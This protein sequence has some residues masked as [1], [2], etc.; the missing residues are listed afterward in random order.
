MKNKKRARKIIL[1][2]LIG[3]I[4]IMLIGYLGIAFIIRVT[5]EGSTINGIDC[6]NK[7]VDEVKESIIEKINEYTLKIEE[8]GGKTETIMAPQVKLSYVDDNRVD[9][10]MDEQE[11][12]KWPLSF[13]SSKSYEMAANTTFDE[14]LVDSVMD[15]MSCFQEENIEKP[16]NAYMQ[17]K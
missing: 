15:D 12:Y 14:A 7:T 8:R 1:G 17:E 11:Q 16:K 5:F 6:S 9:E 10:L 3:Y 2:V 4:A 13:S